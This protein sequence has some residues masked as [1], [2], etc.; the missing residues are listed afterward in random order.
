L[1]SP[2]DEHAVEGRHARDMAFLN[3]DVIPSLRL[4][5]LAVRC[6]KKPGAYFALDA[7]GILVRSMYLFF[8]FGDGCQPAAASELIPGSLK[9]TKPIMPFNPLV[10]VA[11]QQ[12]QYMLY[13]SPKNTKRGFL[14]PCQTD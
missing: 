12:E 13:S 10:R 1:S 6:S 7:R 3:P 11:A 9:A 2:L 8:V 4:T 5:R 14:E